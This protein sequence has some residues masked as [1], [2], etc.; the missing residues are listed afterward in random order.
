MMMI[1]I[2]KTTIIIIIINSLD[3]LIFYMNYFHD[4]SR[5]HVEMS[6]IKM[7]INKAV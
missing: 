6:E 5:S 4:D 2:V 1:M 7:Y 3:S